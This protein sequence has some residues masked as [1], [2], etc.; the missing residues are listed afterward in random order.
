MER[1]NHSSEYQSSTFGRIHPRYIS[2]QL[3]TERKCRPIPP[4]P[5]S[6]TESIT[7]A[8]SPP[9]PQFYFWS[10]GNFSIQNVNIETKVVPQTLAPAFISQR[11]RVM[12][13]P[14]VH[15][16]FFL[17]LPRERKALK[18]DE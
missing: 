1:V 12:A 4:P 5:L 16:L 14:F 18:F 8:I 2:G 6:G 17:L 7:F 3:T 13:P 15:L 10:R 11:S 9:P